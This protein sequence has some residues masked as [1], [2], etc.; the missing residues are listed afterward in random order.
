[1]S[2]TP[3]QKENRPVKHLNMKVIHNVGLHARPAAVFVQEANA[4]ESKIEV[5]NAS[6]DSEW[7]DAK[8]ILG[9]LTLGV[10]QDHDIEIT[11][12]GSDEEEASEALESLIESNFEGRL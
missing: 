4:Y 8:S 10:E 9:V 2:K 7:V 12:E 5:R 11:I 6:K 1:M 3:F